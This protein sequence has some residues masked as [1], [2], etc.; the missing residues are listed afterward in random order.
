MVSVLFELRQ[1]KCEGMKVY[2]A[3]IIM[4]WFA[5]FLMW[6][7][8]CFKYVYDFFVVQVSP[9][10][11]Y[12]VSKDKQKHSPNHACV[13]VASTETIW[14]QRCDRAVL[15]RPCQPHGAHQ[16]TAEEVGYCFLLHS[17]FGG[18]NSPELKTQTCTNSVKTANNNSHLLIFLICFP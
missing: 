7:S 2:E 3:C 16:G 10:R 8:F 11:K 13:L 4:Q 5:H 9:Y 1:D 12:K 18:I 6:L 15:S 14:C 17:G